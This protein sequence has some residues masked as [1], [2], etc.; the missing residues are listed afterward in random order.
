MRKGRAVLAALLLAAM[1]V[2]CGEESRTQIS[3]ISITREGE[4]SHHIVGTFDQSY[5]D[6]E[7]LEKLTAQRVESYC[8]EKGP[9][10]VTVGSLEEKDGTISIK[11]EYQSTADYAAFNNRQLF[12]GTVEEAEAAGYKLDEVAL[13]SL[14]RKPFE[15][16]D[17]DGFETMSVAIIETAPDEQL[18]VNVPGKVLYINQTAENSVEVAADGKKSVKIQGKEDPAEEGNV[19]SY[20]IYK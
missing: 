5:Y 7:G 1:A 15:P 8:S 13:V 20:I 10:S 3:E 19:L 9:G 2:G 12:D 17:I 14:D 11:M 6:K 18:K 16:G 4:V